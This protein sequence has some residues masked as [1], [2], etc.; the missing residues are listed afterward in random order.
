MKKRNRSIDGHINFF[1]EES[2]LK[3][4]PFA[5]CSIKLIFMSFRENV[6]ACDSRG[7]RLLSM[8]GQA[9]EKRACLVFVQERSLFAR[10]VEI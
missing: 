3:Q 10:R 5:Y 4:E 1:R 6:L 9:E 7:Y 8:E 2:R